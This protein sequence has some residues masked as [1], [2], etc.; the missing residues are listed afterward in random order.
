[1]RG[2]MPEATDWLDSP[3]SWRIVTVW[4]LIVVSTG[5]RV[6]SACHTREFVSQ[7]L[8]R[9]A[10]DAARGVRAPGAPISAGGMGPALASGVA[11]ISGEE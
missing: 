4:I 3:A 11:R 5:R 9:F 7:A 1:M 2:A 8:V 10:G 6:M